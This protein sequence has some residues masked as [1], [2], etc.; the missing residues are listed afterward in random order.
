MEGLYL[1]AIVSTPSRCRNLRFLSRVALRNPAADYSIRLGGSRAG[2]T[3]R[4]A[5]RVAN[6]DGPWKPTAGAASGLPILTAW[7]TASGSSSGKWFAHPGATARARSPRSPAG[8][9][10]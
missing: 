7:A 4:H 3:H 6:L 10:E 8:G 1:A 9:T 5:P 2:P